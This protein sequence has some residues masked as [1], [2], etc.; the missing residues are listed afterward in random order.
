MADIKKLPIQH[1][2]AL[3]FSDPNGISDVTPWQ[4]DF[5]QI[6][7]G[8]INTW[9][10]VR[11]GANLTL[12]ETGISRSVHQTG[13]APKGM[14]TLGIPLSAGV[15]RWGGCDTPAN[16][17]L[18]FGEAGGFDG[19]SDATFHGVTFSAPKSHVEGL[20]DRLKLPITGVD[21]T[22]STFSDDQGGARLARVARAAQEMVVPGSDLPLTPEDEEEI[23]TELLMCISARPDEREGSTVS[24]RARALSRA[25]EYLVANVEENPPVSRICQEAGISYRT[26]NRAF[27]ESFEVGPKAYLLRMRLG[28]ARRD[29]LTGGTDVMIADVANRWGFWHMGQFAKD[30]AKN[31]G[32]LPSQTARHPV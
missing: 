27:H 30:Y 11:Q 5:R 7:P 23:L 8:P 9:I 19:L 29:L 20:V 22:C 4:L 17:A 31:F 3:Q 10:Q 15:K 16:S 13:A 21:L 12:L 2:V 18:V 25:L 32:E 1:V 14:V 6:E 28:R 24:A 26:L